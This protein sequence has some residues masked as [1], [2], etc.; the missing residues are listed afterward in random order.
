MLYR[1][2]LG[3]AARTVRLAQNKTLRQVAREAHIALGYLSEI[4]RG[5]KELSSELVV[6]LA[7]SLGMTPAQLVN[8]TVGVMFDWEQQERD[9]VLKEIEQE[10]QLTN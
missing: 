7:E 8:L 4:E 2:A 1:E 10:P 6:G 5:Q 3:Y 9:D